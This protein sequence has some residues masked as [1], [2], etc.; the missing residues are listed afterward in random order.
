[1][2]GF[3]GALAVMLRVQAANHSHERSRS[4]TSAGPG[5]MRARGRANPAGTKLWKK[6]QE[7]KL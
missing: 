4:F 7:G 1:M 3:L 5:K 6:A 2:K